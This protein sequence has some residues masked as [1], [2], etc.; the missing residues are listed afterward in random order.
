MI[1][2]WTLPL[3]VL[4]AT[5]VGAQAQTPK[6]AVLAYRFVPGKVTQEQI[7]V[8]GELRIGSGADA[9]P[10]T[11]DVITTLTRRVVAV[12]PSG[13]ATVTVKSDSMIARLSGAGQ[14]IFSMQDRDG[15][16]TLVNG[17]PLTP[18]GEAPKEV[19]IRMGRGGQV[20]PAG[21]GDDPA[22]RLLGAM[23]TSTAAFPDRSVAI[24]EHWRA[25]TRLSF[26]RLDL[27]GTMPSMP[28]L[29]ATSDSEL[30]SLDRDQ[31]RLVATIV[32]TSEGR[33]NDGASKQ[34]TTMT[35][36]FDVDA[37]ELIESG[38]DL[39]LDLE[40]SDP[41]DPSAAAGKARLT[42]RIHF[43]TLVLSSR[44]AAAET[45]TPAAPV[46]P[47]QPE[48]P[49]PPPPTIPP[50][51]E[52]LGTRHDG[53]SLSGG[54]ILRYYRSPSEQACRSDC[55]RD[56][57]CRGYTW[58]KPGGYQRGDPP[59]CYLMRSYTSANQHRC[60]VSATRGPFPGRQ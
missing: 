6:E 35:S 14:Q 46:P 11:I 3:V 16:S 47:T 51:A 12:A 2:R 23:P 58:V 1:F 54:E 26:P 5:L 37:G 32:T 40:L 49:P 30:H 10:L 55:E 19:T 59:V 41:A 48:Q 42:G 36:R 52:G 25:S 4:S 8:T 43:T 29:T 17:V 60:C 13:E 20:L 45:T 27:G 33:S 50:R 31:G 28:E 39:S 38:G 15:I 18:A 56:S 7:R 21:A 24:G 34:R 57:A 53:W 22:S 9:T 44:M